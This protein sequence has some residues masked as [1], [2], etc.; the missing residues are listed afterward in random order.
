MAIIAILVSLSVF[1]LQSARQ[2]SRDAK[3]KADL[4][5]I[6]TALELY[7]ADCTRY[8]TASSNQVP[9]PLVGSGSCNTNTYMQA[10][11]RDPVAGN[12][13]RYVRHSDTSYSL[14]AYLEGGGTDV[15][16]GSCGSSGNCNYRTTSP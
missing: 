10:V 5:A 9:N 1:A 6:R 7:R 12:I 11:P 4:E 14:C 15:G 8:P 16:C 3:R 13:Y 2:S